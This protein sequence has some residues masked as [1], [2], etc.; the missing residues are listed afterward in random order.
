MA[1]LGWGEMGAVDWAQRG[2][3]LTSASADAGGR[4]G[5]CSQ[6][7]GPPRPPGSRPG[8]PAARRLDWEQGA[9]CTER[10]TSQ[11]AGV[12]RPSLSPQPPS[13]SAPPWSVLADSFPQASWEPSGKDVNLQQKVVLGLESPAAVGALSK[14]REMLVLVSQRARQAAVQFLVPSVGCSTAS[15]VP[16]ALSGPP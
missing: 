14:V 11:V 6:R 16:P 10:H 13:S 5:R 15:V 1:G 8:R 9:L 7:G 12:P 4:E 2:L 3:H